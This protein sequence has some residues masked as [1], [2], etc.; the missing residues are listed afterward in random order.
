MK[1]ITL[2][3][4]LCFLFQIVF[5]QN[6]ERIDWK[7]DLDYLRKELS[8]KHFNF[9][10]VKSK[11]YFEAGIDAI[12]KDCDNLTDVQVA[13]KTQQLIA[14]FGDSH[15]MLHFNQLLDKDKILPLHLLWTS[16]GLHVL[17]TTKSNEEIL[18]CKIS[19]INNVPIATVADS[20]STLLTIDN[21][22]MVKSMAPQFIPSVQLLEYFGFMQSGEVVLTLEDNKSYTLKPEIIDQSNVASFKPESVSFCIAN[23]KVFFTDS[24]F[25]DSKI[26]YI[27]YNKCWGK[28]SELLYGDKDRAASLPSFNEFGDKAFDVLNG[29]PIDKIIF[30]MRFNGGG[31][32]APGSDFI[33]R[34]AEYLNKHPDVKTYVVIGRNT[35]SSAILN[36]MDF[37]KMTNAVFVGE[38]TAGKPNHFGEVKSIQLPGSGLQ[39]GY[40]SNYFKNT[41]EDISTLKPD[42]QIEMSFSDFT[43]GIDPVFEWVKKQ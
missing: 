12:K 6:K 41:E 14:Q 24:Y 5:S 39:V 1:K 11:E 40:S 25:S 10:T 7:T 21:Q 32:S 16:D 18:G 9:F 22:A 29:N 26:Y 34:L 38:E 27:L 37:K 8:E 30:D 17:H 13:I 19:A 23:Q 33:K 20:L 15:T 4:I 35:F 42:V 36:S 2:L 3:S 28:E 31:N 43:K